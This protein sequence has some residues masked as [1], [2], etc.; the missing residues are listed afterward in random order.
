MEK[1][2]YL[3]PQKSFEDIYYVNKI[4]PSPFRR[5]CTVELKIKP[6]QK[7]LEEK[8]K[9]EGEGRIN[10]YIGIRADESSR[11]KGQL[12]S[13][14]EKKYVMIK[15]PLVE[16]GIYKQD[17]EDILKKTGI[18]MPEYY[19]WRS[20]NGCFM[21]FYQ[22]QYDW[23]KLYKNAPK[24]FNKAMEYEKLSKQGHTLRFGLNK[25]L[26]LSEIIKPHN[27]KRI[28][29]KYKILDECRKRREE[30]NKR[31]TLYELFT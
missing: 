15:Y 14:I 20:R 4:L 28:E 2:T 17:V 24:L 5:W 30:K 12:R 22:S 27:M 3:K 26:P 10:L 25:D 21:C 13:E 31:K 18:N 16:N 9:N 23:I 11:A 19:K 6:S 29:E 8:I 1:I 7:F